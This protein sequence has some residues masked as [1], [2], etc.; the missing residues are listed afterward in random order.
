[1]WNEDKPQRALATSELTQKIL[2]MEIWHTL[3]LLVAC[4]LKRAKLFS[5]RREWNSGVAR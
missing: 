1:M 2:G 4:R 5:W 3:R